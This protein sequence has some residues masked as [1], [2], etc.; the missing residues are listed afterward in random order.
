MYQIAICDDEEKCINEIT[1]LLNAFQ[2]NN[3]DIKLSWD[4]YTTSQELMKQV[5]NR[6]YD[7]YLLDSYIDERNGI[8]IAEEIRKQD[9]Q[10]AIVFLTSSDAFYKEAF[11][12]QASQYLEKPFIEQEFF[13]A[14]EQLCRKEKEHYFVVKDGSQLSRRKA[15]DIVF[16][17]SEDHYKRITFDTD[18]VLMRETMTNL[19]Q[20]LFEE[21]FYMLNGKTDVES[22]KQPFSLLWNQ[23]IKLLSFYILVCDGSGNR[24]PI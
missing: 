13:H 2:K 8:D 12:L 3:T 19:K 10:G 14:M 22:L 6:S 15:E 16:I 20:E 7:I 21:Y 23:C 11:R 24:Y 4:S 18:S 9:E 5:S 1:T 17:T